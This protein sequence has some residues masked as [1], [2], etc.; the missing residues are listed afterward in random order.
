MTATAT[1]QYRRLRTDHTNADTLEVNAAKASSKRAGT[2]ICL[3]AGKREPNN[4]RR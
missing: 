4:R 1:G 3:T 2:T